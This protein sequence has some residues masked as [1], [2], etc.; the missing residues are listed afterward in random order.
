MN[1]QLIG[2]RVLYVETETYDFK[3]DESEYKAYLVF[4]VKSRLRGLFDEPSVLLRIFLSFPVCNAS[5]ERAMS[6]LKR[7]KTYIRANMQQHRLSDLALLSV[8]KW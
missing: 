5:C 3:V 8:E 6:V 4:I 7:V 1:P 2:F